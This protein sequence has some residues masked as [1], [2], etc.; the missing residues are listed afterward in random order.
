MV[1]YVPAA[2]PMG[3]DAR[4]TDWVDMQVYKLELEVKLQKLTNELR[5]LIWA[6]STGKSNNSKLHQSPIE[7]AV[8]QVCREGQT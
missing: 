6:S 1:P 4:D 5:E 8:S 2:P 7:R 3:F